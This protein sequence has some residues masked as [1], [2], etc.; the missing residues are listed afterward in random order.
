MVLLSQVIAITFQ[1]ILPIWRDHL[2]PGRVSTLL[3]ANN[4]VYL[5]GYDQSLL[6][7]PVI[8]LAIPSEKYSQNRYKGVVS[9]FK[10][11][12]HLFRLRGLFVFEQHR[13]ERIA[14]LL[15][16]ALVN[17]VVKQGGNKLWTLPRKSNFLFYEKVGFKKTSDWIDNEFEFGP[18]CFALKNLI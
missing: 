14:Q 6:K 15:V 2:W 18:N 13:G 7:N 1:D 16:N 10:T 8:F 12:E 4:I 9:G 3:P 17:E 5:G 11:T